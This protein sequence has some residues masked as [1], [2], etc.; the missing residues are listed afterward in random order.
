MD[1]KIQNSQKNGERYD[2][3][4][5]CTVSL[6]KRQSYQLKLIRLEKSS[7]K[8]Y[9]SKHRVE[10]FKLGSVIASINK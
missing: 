8:I 5:W 1:L 6:F 7:T 4:V 9:T 2:K 3:K 10:E